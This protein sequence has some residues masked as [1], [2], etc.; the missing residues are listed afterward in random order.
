MLQ[1]VQLYSIIN[2]KGLIISVYVLKTRVAEHSIHKQ[3]TD[4][5]SFLFVSKTAWLTHTKKSIE[6][7]LYVLIF[8]T[9]FVGSFFGQEICNE[10]LFWGVE[11]HVGLQA[12]W[13][14]KLPNHNEKWNGLTNFTK[15]SPHVKMNYNYSSNPQ[16][17]SH[18]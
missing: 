13:S 16:A 11:K 3:K 17:V 1:H 8:C 18:V 12:K 5:A 4:A 6:H 14:T 10:P 7:K 9:T 15:I 2:G